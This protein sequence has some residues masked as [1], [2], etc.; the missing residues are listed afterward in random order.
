M[1]GEAGATTSRI[2]GWAGREYAHFA[3]PTPYLRAEDVALLD[4]A[5]CAADDWRPVERALG[6]PVLVR[7][8]QRPRGGLLVLVV[9]GWYPL[10][11]TA[12]TADR[13]GAAGRRALRRVGD[14]VRGAGGRPIG[15]TELSQ[16]VD[17]ARGRWQ[18][19][20]ATQH[21]LEESRPYLEFRSCAR[22][23]DWS[24]LA[25]PHCRHCGHRFTS[26]EDME[27]DTRT[28]TAAD[29]T[30]RCTGQLVALGRGD[31]LFSDWPPP[32][33]QAPPDPRSPHAPL[34]ALPAKGVT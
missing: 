29:V 23:D 21:L 11:L 3:M 10:L 33:P 4:Q 1:P 25:A 24:T 6:Q 27:R 2:R 15:D 19:A 8:W 20:V 14:A 32:G 34:R 28:R 12:G 31:G 9:L 5:T 30:A 18:A 13:A 7:R 26:P 17:A 16:C 22:C